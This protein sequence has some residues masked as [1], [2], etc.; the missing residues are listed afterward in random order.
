LI[1]KVFDKFCGENARRSKNGSAPVLLVLRIN[2]NQGE[3]Y[4]NALASDTTTR[5]LLSIPVLISFHLP[6]RRAFP[7]LV[8]VAGHAAAG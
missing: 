3:P 7:R 8:L 4:A 2:K 5:F 6:A 1:H